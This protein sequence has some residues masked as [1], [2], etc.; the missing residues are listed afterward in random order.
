[1]PITGGEIVFVKNCM[2]KS[3][4]YELRTVGEWSKLALEGQRTPSRSQNIHKVTER[5][6]IGS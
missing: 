2:K 3:T 5:T 4:M 1:M 6:F